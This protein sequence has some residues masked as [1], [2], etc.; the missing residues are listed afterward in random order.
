M[1]CFGAIIIKLFDVS[2][3]IVLLLRCTPRNVQDLADY[4]RTKLALPVAAL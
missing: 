3:R 1:F 4:V 2:Y